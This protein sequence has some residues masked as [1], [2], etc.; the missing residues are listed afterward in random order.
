MA[1]IIYFSICMTHVIF[2][3]GQYIMFSYCK[4][5]VKIGSW[6]GKSQEKVWKFHRLW[7]VG[8]LTA[9]EW[10][11]SSNLFTA[12]SWLGV[13]WVWCWLR[14]ILLHVLLIRHC[15]TTAARRCRKPFS[16]WQRSFHLKAAMPLAERIAK[17][18]GSCSKSRVNCLFRVIA[19][20]TCLAHHA[21]LVAEEE[22]AMRARTVRI[23]CAFVLS[24]TIVVITLVLYLLV[25][26][27]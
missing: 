25:G 13:G 12:V 14:I 23:I 6:S 17:A 27:K 3:E 26:R 24:C 16:L 4:R 11:E 19:G 8:T 20:E 21:T 9:L 10:Y 5:S 22:Q 1:T 18:S 15:I 7:P 2:R